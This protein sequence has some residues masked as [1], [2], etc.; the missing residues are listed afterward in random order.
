[1]EREI[2]SLRERIA[3]A[4][5]SIAEADTKREELIAQNEDLK[6]SAGALTA[7]LEDFERGMQELL[8]RLPAPIRD[9]VRPLSQRLPEPDAQEIDLTVSERFQNVIGILNEIDKFH[10]TVAVTS[11]VRELPDGSGAEVT[12]LYLGIGRG[13]YVGAN[14]TVA[15]TGS[16]ADGEW[17]WT[18]DNDA[19]PAVAEAI[20]IMENEQ[21]ASF[22]P[23][24]LVTETNVRGTQ[25]P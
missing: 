25:T 2:E 22:V 11:E 17:T 12:A 15:G 6:E 9:R 3:E 21:V 14:N 1:V 20:A 10:R 5:E 23:L 24:P 7:E 16:G 18:S 8:P 19:A 13:W 4:E